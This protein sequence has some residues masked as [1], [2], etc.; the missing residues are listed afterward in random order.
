M[1]SLLNNSA[2]NSEQRIDSIK[3]ADTIITYMVMGLWVFGIAI[4]IHY[5]TWVLGLG[6]GSLLAIVHLTAFR[7][8]PTKLFS[9][10]IG[11]SVMAFYMIQYL[12]QLH[13]LYEIHF[14]FFIMPMFLITYQD[15]RVYIPFALIIVIHHVSIY[16]LVVGQGR[17]EFLPYFINMSVLTNMTFFYHM[18]LAV[19]GV[20][21]AAWIAYRL[22]TQTTKRFQGAAK[23]EAQLDEMKAL[24][25]NVKQV[26]SRI[27]NKE[28]GSE[29]ESVN[30]ALV[31]LGEEFNNIIDNI[32]VETNTVVNNAGREGDLSSRMILENKYGVWKDLAVSINELLETISEPV[33]QI[34]SV[35]SNMSR[36]MLTDRISTESKGAIKDL[37]NNLNTALDNLRTLLMQVSSGINKIEDATSDMLVSSEEMDSSTNEIAT[38]IA[39][40]STGAHNQLQDIEKTSNVIEM[41]VASAEEM[42][43]DATSI[44]EAAHKG[45]ETSEQG[46]NVVE[47]VVHDIKKIEEFSGKTMNSINVL[48]QRSTEIAQMLNVINEIASQTNLLAL[49]A[50]IEAAQAGDNG[51]G[52]AVVA[53]EIKKLAESAKTSTEEIEKIVRDVQNDTEE[54]AKIISEMNKNVISG[55]ESTKKTHEMLS[56]ISAGSKHTLD[57]SHRIK[58]ITQTQTKR[59]AEVFNSVESVLLISEQAATGAEEVASSASQLSSGMRDFNTNSKLLKDLGENLKK[60][61]DQFTLD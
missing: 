38:A 41:I 45:Y 43:H 60:S 18:G 26:A 33:V 42:E 40:M 12:V 17:D 19:I 30:E 16:I 39:K 50:A 61:M 59:I 1:I 2:S 23:L 29:S 46:K 11:A 51:R 24:A 53:D 10:M 48:S 32:I 22:Q 34:N 58:E 13:G 31:S 56:T 3:Q 55:V 7:F 37:Y 44:N 21:T 6:M 52:F 5:D 25:L 8:F 4:S 15:W 49:N 28:Q 35:A 57:L 47:V 27:T 54:A 14:W 36:G 9:R 20:V